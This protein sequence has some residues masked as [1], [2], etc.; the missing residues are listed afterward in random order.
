MPVD[1]VLYSFRSQYKPRAFFLLVMPSNGTAAMLPYR[2]FQAL[3]LHRDS[4]CKQ[5]GAK[6]YPIPAGNYRSNTGS[7]YRELLSFAEHIADFF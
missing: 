1:N 5:T 6:V 3:R 2:C 4:H 7:R